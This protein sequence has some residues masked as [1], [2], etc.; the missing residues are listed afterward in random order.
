MNCGR[1]NS[2]QANKN[3]SDTIHFIQY[4]IKNKLDSNEDLN[5]KKDTHTKLPNRQHS[6]SFELDALHIYAICFFHAVL[7]SMLFL[8]LFISSSKLYLHLSFTFR[9]H[10]K[11]I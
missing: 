8:F 11:S 3:D 2:M 7:F 9:L 1:F 6:T 10:F 5:K 4:G